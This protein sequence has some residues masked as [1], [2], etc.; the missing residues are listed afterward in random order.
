MVTR[1]K[2]SINSFNINLFSIFFGPGIVLDTGDT[3]KYKAHI[4]LAVIR[5]FTRGE[6]DRYLIN[7]QD[8][9]RE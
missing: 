7:K 4:G 6:R 5:L 2:S 3:M 8:K 1:E 9:F